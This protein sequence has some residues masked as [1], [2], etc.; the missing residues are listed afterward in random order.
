[1]A[2]L[3]SKAISGLVWSAVERVG[4]QA[5]VFVIQVILARLLAPEQFGLIAMVVVFMTLSAVMVDFGFSSALIQ[6][7]GIADTELSTV[8]YFN[9]VISCLMTGVLWLIAP[10]VAK[11]YQLEELTPILRLL[12]FRLILGAF[13]AVQR[14]ILT[15]KMLFKRLFKVSLP[16]TLIGGAVAIVMALQGY[17]AWALVVQ[18]LIQSLIMSLALWFHSDWHPKLIFDLQ[19]LKK[20]FPY[21]SRLAF[22]SF[23]HQGFLNIYILV[24]GKA[25]S[26]ADLGYFHRARS[27]QRL[28]IENVQSIL[29][30]VTFPLFSSIQDDLPRMKR[31]MSKALQLSSICIFPGM[32]LLAA[33]AT[34]L[35]V[36]LIGVK[37]LPSVPYLKWLCLFGAM[38]PLHSM[39]VN[40]LSAIGRSDLMLR[41]EL[42]KKSLILINVFITYRYGILAMIY[43][44]IV[45]SILGLI[46]NTYYT[47]KF[48]DYS[49]MQQLKDISPM[50]LLG[51]GVFTL[52]S[53]TQ[54]FGLE[55]NLFSL[56][57]GVVVAGAVFLLALPFMPEGIRL[58]ISM[59][60]S[61]FAFISRPLSTYL[62]VQDR[63]L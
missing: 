44:M 59:F 8:F 25:F 27:L 4:Q 24:I 20:M 30:R 7:K 63:S 2:T 31:G 12:S 15:R 6:R 56:L 37:W 10:F 23:I 36:V 11:F 13:G 57:I 52:V 46:I 49:F 54:L 21:S 47:K 48:I 1:M 50:I 61:R 58:E 53:F 22:S 45:T 40:L 62:R 55:S 19:C 17:G 14:S 33:I 16:S 43:G 41:L 9:I 51:V 60:S 35:I 29:G 32:A 42:I 18:A 26:V 39:N 5:V 34:P 38:F 3:R 28:P